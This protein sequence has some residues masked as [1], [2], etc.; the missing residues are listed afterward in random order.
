MEQW[1][2]HATTDNAHVASMADVLILAVK[3]QSLHAMLTPLISVFNPQKTLLISI[4]A[5]ITTS[6]IQQWLAQPALAMIRAM[7]NTPALYG[8]G[9]T[10]LFATSTVSEAQ[11]Q[12]AQSLLDAVG[13]TVWVASEAAMDVVTALSG[14]GPAYYFY[15]MEALIAGATELGLPENIARELTLHTA[16]GSAHMALHSADPLSQ[17]RKNVTSPGGTTE[18]GINVLKNGKLD[19][20]LLAALRAAASRAQSLADDYN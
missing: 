12:T 5:G 13:K 16:L 1:G 3:P 15:F 14:S 10:G 17:L 4:A 9:I 8:K 20:L 7:P 19:T 11:K 18:Q 2:I 6:H